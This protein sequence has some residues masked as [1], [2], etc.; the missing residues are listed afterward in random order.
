MVVPY[1]VAGIKKQKTRILW[2]VRAKFF[3]HHLREL[4]RESASA[5]DDSP[6]HEFS[7]RG[8]RQPLL[9]TVS[10]L[11][12][13]DQAFY[14]SVEIVDFGTSAAFVA[15]RLRKSMSVLSE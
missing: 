1:G 14:E 6:Q 4:R 7:L 13:M 10:I 15:Q 5:F 3:R 8:F 2:K 9:V 12:Q 11:E